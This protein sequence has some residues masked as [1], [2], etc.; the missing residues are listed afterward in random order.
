MNSISSQ[1]TLTTDE[2]V[3]FGLEGKERQ[4]AFGEK[5]THFRRGT[6]CRAPGTGDNPDAP[7]IN[8]RRPTIVRADRL[9]ENQLPG[10]ALTIS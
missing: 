3:A 4:R 8:W 1:F 7:R 6:W 10:G 5:C 9:P 2:R